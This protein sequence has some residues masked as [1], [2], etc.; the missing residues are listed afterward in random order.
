MSEK[1][2]VTYASRLGSTAGVA[3]TIGKT[4]AGQGVQVDVL[5]MEDVKDLAPY[6]AVV[7]G[8]AIRDR[9]WLPEAVDFVRTNRAELS[10]KPFAVFLVCMTLA[11]P[12]AAQ[13]RQ[14]VSEWL[15]PVRG[16]RKAGKRRH[17]CWNPGHQQ[18]P[19]L[20]RP[21]GVS[22]QRCDRGLVGGRSPGLECGPRLG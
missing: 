15:Q 22:H 6:R 19:L 7:A 11:M 14:G 2:L 8:S 17:V 21:G 3:E 16:S 13:Y 9:Q 1:I 5:R 4:L 18:D 10:R 12:N 20:E